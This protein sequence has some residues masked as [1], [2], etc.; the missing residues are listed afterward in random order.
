VQEDI[1]GR[2]EAECERE[3]LLAAEHEQR[4]LAEILR[5]VT[6]SL[7]AHTSHEAVLNEILRQVQ[8]LVACTTANIIL[9]EAD[10][11]M[12]VAC[13]QGY[14]VFGSEEFISRII[15]PL[16]SIPLYLDVVCLQKPLVIQ[17]TRQEPR[18]VT[19]NQTAWVRSHLAVPISHHND[20]LGLLLL[21]GDSPGE[22]ST[23]DAKRLQPLAGAAAIALINARLY[24]QALKNAESRAVLLKEVN[25]RVKNNLSAIIGLL[26][27]A[28]GHAKVADE[29]AYQAM[30]NDMIT[31]IEALSTVHNLLSA[32]E[33]LPLPLDD[34][35]TQI[36]AV[37]IQTVPPEK[38][39]T[40]KVSPSPV[41]VSPKQANH[42]AIVVNELT[43]NTIKYAIEERPQAAINV[44]IDQ[45]DDRISF[46]FEDDGPGYPPETLRLER[47][48]VGLDLMQ[49]LVG[50]DLA[51]EL[52]LQNNHGAIT[53]I[54]FPAG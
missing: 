53:C 49:M 34:L 22:F 50:R 48:G 15:L 42:V 30:M 2:K 45:G 8:R 25:H 44:Y 26:Y 10:N 3:Q 41:L 51:G 5:Q 6:L 24:E 13:W 38:Y 11:T 1:S 54:S 20:I 33:W 4:L 17:D 21:D 43:T 40:V 47:Y 32:A 9:L 31:R 28:Q 39:I 52:S 19:F 37:A 46:R 7:A 12:R 29:T 18:W 23:E 35:I 36:I 16:E 27:T 14:D